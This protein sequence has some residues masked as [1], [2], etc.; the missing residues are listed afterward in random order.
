MNS[1]IQQADCS[2]ENRMFSGLQLFFVD[3]PHWV[4]KLPLLQCF[5]CDSG[6]ALL[7]S[8]QAQLMQ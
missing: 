7:Y 4:L 2:F 1:G 3:E 5:A 8:A 6:L